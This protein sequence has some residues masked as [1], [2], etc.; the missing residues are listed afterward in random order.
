MA[1]TM[2]TTRLV[3]DLRDQAAPTEVGVERLAELLAVRD[4]R[5]WLDISDPGEDEVALLRQHFGFHELTLEEVTRPHERPRC[6]AHP[7]YYFIVMYAAEHS[8]G[9]FQPREL[10]V[11]WGESFMVTIHR[12]SACIQ[13]LLREARRR[14]EQHEDRPAHGV[15]ALAYALFETLVDGYFAVQDRVREQI[16]RIEEAIFKGEESAAADLFRLRKELLRVPRL[17]APTSHVLE[18]VLRRERAIPAELRPYF[19]D[20][21]DHLRH[22]LA[23]MDTYRDLLTTALDVQVFYSF[24]R[25]GHIMKRLTAVTVIIMVPNF[26]ASIYGMNFDHVFP[27]SEWRFGFYLVVG[28]LACMVAWGFIHSRLMRWL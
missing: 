1:A 26:V 23:E 6:D 15:P 19:G 12:G 18:E 28:F 9:E 14:W 20:V 8:G 10:N 22:V 11:F 13:G 17:L 25:L 2:G 21:E 27:P 4:N 5:L 16:E 24:N 7:G 3:L